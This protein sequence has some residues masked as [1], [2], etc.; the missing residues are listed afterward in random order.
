MGRNALSPHRAGGR[1]PTATP[2]LQRAMVDIALSSPRDH[3]LAFGPQTLDRLRDAFVM[4]CV[5]ELISKIPLREA[6]PQ[7]GGELPGREE[8]A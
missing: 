8:P 1:P 2:P 7:E 6:P 5:V 4:E 3:G